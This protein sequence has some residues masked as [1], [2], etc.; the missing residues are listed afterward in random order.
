MILWFCSTGPWPEKRPQAG[1]RQSAQIGIVSLV[2]LLSVGQDTAPIHAHGDDRIY[3]VVGAGIINAG[4]VSLV[5]GTVP[6]RPVRVVDVHIHSGELALAP[7]ETMMAGVRVHIK[8][9]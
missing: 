1:V 7:E 2:F 5:I 3:R 8:A 6:E 9:R 4:E